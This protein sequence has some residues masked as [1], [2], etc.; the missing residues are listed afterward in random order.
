MTQIQIRG[1]ERFGVRT[2][3]AEAR[4]AWALHRELDNV[5]DRVYETGRWAITH[6]PTGTKLAVARSAVKARRMLAVLD[7]SM[8]TFPMSADAALTA[9]TRYGPTWYRRYPAVRAWRKMFRDVV[10]AS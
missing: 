7:R 1:S 2:I 10:R 6:R 8:P 4:G 5:G 9:R 3:E